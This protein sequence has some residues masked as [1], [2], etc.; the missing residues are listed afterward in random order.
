MELSTSRE[1]A[2]YAATRELPSILLNPEVCYL[3]Q[4]SPLLLP[5]LSQTNPLH[6]I[7]SSLSKI[8]FNSLNP[9]TY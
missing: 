1:V 8:H 3:L 5:F 7:P 4:N 2:S 9:P 6:I